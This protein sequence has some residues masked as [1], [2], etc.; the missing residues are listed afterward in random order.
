MRY[1]RSCHSVQIVPRDRRPPRFDG[2]CRRS[3]CSLKCSCPTDRAGRATRS[4]CCRARLVARRVEVVVMAEWVATRV[5]VGCHDQSGTVLPRLGSAA[6]S[7]ACLPSADVG[8]GSAA[9]CS[10]S[11][12]HAACRPRLSIKTITN[13]LRSEQVMAGATYFHQPAHRSR[14]T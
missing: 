11:V 2:R 8:F 10:G 3:W 6:F 12:L 14:Q 7:S 5:A 13:E 4:C 9:R 1:R